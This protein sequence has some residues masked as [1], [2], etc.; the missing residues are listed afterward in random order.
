GAA[1]AL[2]EQIDVDMLPDERVVYDA[3]VGALREAMKPDELTA[4]WRSGRALDMET[5]VNLALSGGA[6]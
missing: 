1:E 6:G 4:A 2:R 3:E 5:A